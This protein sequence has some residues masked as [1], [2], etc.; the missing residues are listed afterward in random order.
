MLPRKKVSDTGAHRVNLRMGGAPGRTAFVGA[1]V[2]GIAALVVEE[3]RAEDGPAEECGGAGV[4][5][6]AMWAASALCRMSL[7]GAGESRVA[8]PEAEEEEEDSPDLAD[9]DGLV[10][11]GEGHAAPRRLR[12]VIAVDWTRRGHIVRF[13]KYEVVSMGFDAEG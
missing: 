7:T 1:V 12:L 4:T 6:A 11:R 3:Q 5:G 13:P 8:V 10:Q 9:L 2:A